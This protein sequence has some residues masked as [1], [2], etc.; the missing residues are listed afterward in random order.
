[1]Q[2]ELIEAGQAFGSTPRQ[3]LW[4]IQLPLAMRTIMTGVNQTLMLALSMVVIGALIGAGG[5]G[6]T[7]YTGLGRLDIGYAS[8]GGLGIVLMAIVLDRITQAMAGE[9][10]PVP[11][12]GG[13]ATRGSMTSKGAR[14]PESRGGSDEIQSL[15]TG[16]RP[17]AGA[18]RC[19][20]RPGAGSARRGQDG[21]HGPAHL[22]HRMVPGADLQEGRRAARLHRRGPDRPRQPALLRGGRPRRHRLL[23]ERLVPAAQHLHGPPSKARRA[24]SATSPRAARCRAT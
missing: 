12:Q 4:E 5:L 8:I 23:G 16:V 18:G 19:R 20:P 2:T 13:G 15:V 21:A 3:I 9:G 10:R 7:V 17:G 11:P 24:P 1:M 14:R 6:L 22:G